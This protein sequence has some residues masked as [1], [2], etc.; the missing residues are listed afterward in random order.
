MKSFKELVKET[1]NSLKMFI[2][3]YKEYKSKFARFNHTVFKDERK[4]RLK[5]KLVLKREPRLEDSKDVVNPFM[6]YFLGDAEN[7]NY[8]NLLNLVESR[9]HFREYDYLCF[10]LSNQVNFFINQIAYYYYTCKNSNV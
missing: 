4:I 8:K 5:R 7:L 1:T 3:Y 2:E 10:V 6:M 9:N